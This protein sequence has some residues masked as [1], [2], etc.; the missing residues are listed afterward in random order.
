MLFHTRSIILAVAGMKKSLA[1][2]LTVFAPGGIRSWGSSESW[3]QASSFCDFWELQ[4][5]LVN[6]SKPGNG[7]LKGVARHPRHF[8][9][10]AGPASKPSCVRS[11]YNFLR[12]DLM[13][14]VHQHRG[15]GGGLSRVWSLKFKASVRFRRFQSQ[16]ECSS[17]SSTMIT[18]IK[19]SGRQAPKEH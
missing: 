3:D 9:Q 17:G 10:A 18:S 2:V 4:P 16:P 6:Y 5:F 12:C 11:H 13:R 1:L 15:G 14:L 19:P 8:G 7:R